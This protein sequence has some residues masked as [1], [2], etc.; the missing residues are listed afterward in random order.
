MQALPLMV[1]SFS[2]GA[3]SCG[4]FSSCRRFLGLSGRP[5]QAANIP[6]GET[7]SSVL[8]AP[9]A[10]ELL[11]TGAL[12]RGGRRED[13]VP[14]APMASRATKSTRV[15]TT[16]T[17]ESARPSLRDGFNSFLRALPGDRALLSP[18][19]ARC[20]SI[21]ANLAPT[22]G[23]QNHT[24]SPSAP[25]LSQKPVGRPGTSRAEA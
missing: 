11:E 14:A 12:V 15:R 17:A 20:A 21:V 2:A 25:R 8:A 16:G 6:P 10:S 19:S 24:P 23:R 13:R 1:N 18:S 7:R 3:S 5:W 4:G 9:T 22:L